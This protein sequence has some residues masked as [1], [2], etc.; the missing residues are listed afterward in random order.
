MLLMAT[1]SVVLSERVLNRLSQNQ[2]TYLQG[3]AGSYL[4]GVAASVSPSVLRR[5]NWEIYDALLR[6]KPQKASVLPRETV[7]TDANDIVLASDKP[8]AHPTLGLM[9]NAFRSDFVGILIR[10]DTDS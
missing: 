5:D 1:V 9:D 2:E 3:L 8:E 4:D 7:V 10:L 6:M